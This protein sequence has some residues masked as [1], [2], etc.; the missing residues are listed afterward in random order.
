MMKHLKYNEGDPQLAEFITG[1]N[2]QGIVGL[3]VLIGGPVLKPLD[4]NLELELY[5]VVPLV[6]VYDCLKG[7]GYIDS[8]LLYYIIFILK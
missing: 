2:I 5:D 1:Q 8:Q 4:S 6:Q 3:E 7:C